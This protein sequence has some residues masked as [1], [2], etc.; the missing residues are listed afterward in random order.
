MATSAVVVSNH[1]LVDIIAGFGI[2]GLCI[3]AVLI[4]FKEKD[5]KFGGEME[6]SVP[7]LAELEAPLS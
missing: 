4:I 1:Y 2:A 7:G 5:L 3:S 6:V